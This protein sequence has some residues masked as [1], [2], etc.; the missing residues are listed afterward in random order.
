MATQFSFNPLANPQR[1]SSPTRTSFPFLSGPLPGETKE[2]G[3][4]S[5]DD[6]LKTLIG[7]MPQMQQARTE[8]NLARLPAQFQQ[9]G[10]ILFERSFGPG[11][12]FSPTTRARS[13]TGGF[14][15]GTVGSTFQ[16]FLP[17]ILESLMGGPQGLPTRESLL[18]PRLA[19]LE[20][21]FGGERKALLNRFAGAGRDVTGSVPTEQLGEL[22]SRE[23]LERT[24]AM[25]DVDTL[26]AQLGIQSGAAGASRLQA[27]AAIMQALG[28]GG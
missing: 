11:G 3:A 4:F 28:I 22:G 8:A 18:N 24:R 10:P 9:S 14:A 13:I 26:L 6:I 27:I 17:R 16:Q 15:P 23:A 12:E 19:D 25:G 20:R 2:E 5:M 7:Q 21:T 1:S